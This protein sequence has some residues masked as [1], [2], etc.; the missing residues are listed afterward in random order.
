MSTLYFDPV[1][2]TWERDQESIDEAIVDALI[3]SL[4]AAEL[5]AL[6]ESQP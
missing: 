3:D 6:A 4:S 2:D 5:H 1:L